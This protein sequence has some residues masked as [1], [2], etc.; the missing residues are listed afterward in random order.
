M[1]GIWVACGGGGGGNNPPPA[2]PVVSLS[3]TSLTFSRQN[4]GTTSA[5]KTATL[6]NTGGSSLNISGI[7][8]IGANPYDFAQTTTCGASVAAGA[9]CAINVTFAPTA[10]GSRSAT[11]QRL[12]CGERLGQRRHPYDVRY[13]N[14]TMRAVVNEVMEPGEN[15]GSG[16]R[17]VNRE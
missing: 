1:V 16:L 11:R 3:V 17:V 5:A 13:G 14:R 15:R 8:V 2:A 9:N 6:S 12:D 4:M 7:T 10:L